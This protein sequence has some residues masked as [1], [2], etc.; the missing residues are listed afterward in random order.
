MAV[1]V[2]PSMSEIQNRLRGRW[3]LP[4]GVAM[5]GV[6][7]VGRLC[8]LVK[9][10]SHIVFQCRNHRVESLVQL[11]Y[12]ERKFRDIARSPIAF[13]LYLKSSYIIELLHIRE[14]KER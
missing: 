4:L 9:H 7:Y 12:V 11:E 5:N 13:L 6:D 8:F 2:L 10:I 14:E 1:E 3:H